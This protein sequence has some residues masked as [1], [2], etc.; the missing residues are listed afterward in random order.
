MIGIG[1]VDSQNSK[2][3]QSAHTELKE[4]KDLATAWHQLYWQAHTGS[5]DLGI[6]S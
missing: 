4:W 6:N 3:R 1:H 5:V 2:A